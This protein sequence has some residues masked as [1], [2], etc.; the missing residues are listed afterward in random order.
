MIGSG[1]STLPL[2]GL[3]AAV[4]RKERAM[5]TWDGRSNTLE[6]RDARSGSILWRGKVFVEDDRRTHAAELKMHGDLASGR[7]G[8]WSVDVLLDQSRN[9]LDLVEIRIEPTPS[10]QL[11]RVFVRIPGGR[12]SLPEL[13]TS[14][15]RMVLL[16]HGVFVEKGV[17]TLGGDRGTVVSRFLTVLRPNHGGPSILA[18][19]GALADDLSFFQVDGKALDAGFEPRR[20]LTRDEKYVLAF[21]AGDDPIDLLG[22]YG[23]YLSSF[24]RRRQPSVAGWNSWDYYGASVG[25][26]DLRAEMAAI[27]ATPLADKLTHF[28]IDMGWWADWGENVPN[29]RFLASFRSI[30]KEI[31]DAGFVPGIWHAP[32]LASPWS[33][34]G[35]HRQD[36]FVQAENGGPATV[37][38]SAILDWSNPEVIEQMKGFFRSLRRA[39]FGYFKLDYIYSDAIHQSGTR[40]DDTRGA[41]AI[42]RNGFR[43]IREAVGDDGYILNCGAARECSVGI[44]DAS[45]ISTDIHT[46]WGHV[47]H[48]TREIAC[49]LWENGNLWNID[50]DF[51]L[52]RSKETTD[53]PFPNYIYR[54]R[55]WEDR[56]HFWMAG[57]EASFEELKV[58]LTV[59]HLVGGDVV[60][61]DSIARLNRTGIAALGKLFPRMDQSARPLDLFHSTIPRFWL[62][63]SGRRQRLGVFNW[64]DEARPI[65]VPAGLDVPSEGTDVWTSRRVRLTEKTVMPP[66]SA[67]LLKV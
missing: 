3:A 66:R 12:H 8:P 44:A 34:A 33:R 11:R 48:N 39:G 51:A 31:E 58:W 61:S 24:A 18:G 35:R 23:R 20:V 65:S 17:V 63:Q 43:A 14:D 4:G 7:A 53:D 29:R 27:K 26:D 42:I 5:I 56:N 9:G 1:I 40:H 62:G 28:I 54:H 38:E 15:T 50:P 41:F 30:A 22:T 47:W 10:H 67:Y 57:P 59:V 36:L 49:H 19:V 60:L 55:P 16:P 32:L 64:D 37:G 46:F 2:P 6:A 13:N 25:M 45:R 21:G 52:V